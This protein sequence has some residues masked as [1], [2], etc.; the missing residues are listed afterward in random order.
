VAD[1]EKHFDPPAMGWENLYKWNSRTDLEFAFNLIAQDF[2]ALQKFYREVAAH[3][4]AVLV[5]VD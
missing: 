5:V 2:D 3:S 4:E 1:L